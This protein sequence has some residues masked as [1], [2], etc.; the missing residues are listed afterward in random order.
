MS[1]LPRA[2]ALRRVK[3]ELGPDAIVVANTRWPGGVEITA[4]SADS[5]DALSQRRPRPAAPAPAPRP[6]LP[7]AAAPARGRAAAAR[8]MTTTTRSACP[9]RRARR[10][11][12]WQAPSQPA[13]P[14]PKATRPP[15]RPLPP[16]R[17]AAVPSIAQVAAM[18][19]DTGDAESPRRP[20]AAQVTQLM[21]EMQ[22]IKSMLERQLAG[23]AWGEMSRQTPAQALLLSEMLDAGFSSVLARKLSDDM[24]PTCPP[25]RAA[26]G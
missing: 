18:L 25:T 4:M 24:P 22:T 17:E 2:N 14:A 10:S 8:S 6:E 12:A 26:S 23:F 7:R 15:L 5:L 1:P 20:P 19:Q 21:N 11:R 9:P 3:E 13:A 16:R